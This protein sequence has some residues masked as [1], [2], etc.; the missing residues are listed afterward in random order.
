MSSST[1]VEGCHL[2]RPFFF[3]YRHLLYALF[4]YSFEPGM[5]FPNCSKHQTLK[6]TPQ[7]KINLSLG[8]LLIAYSES[9]KLNECLRTG[10]KF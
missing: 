7:V 10:A 5:A 2:V 4:G 8:K 3:Q 6:Q 1:L 9:H